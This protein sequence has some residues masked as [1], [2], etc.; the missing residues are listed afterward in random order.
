MISAIGISVASCWL[1]VRHEKIMAVLGPIR[2]LF[3]LLLGW[4]LLMPGI[5]TV[6]VQKRKP[7]F[8]VAIDTS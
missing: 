4:C 1:F 6:E 8:L 2:L 3:F 7:H 5:K